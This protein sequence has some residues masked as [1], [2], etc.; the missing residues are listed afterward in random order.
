MTF[1]DFAR[2]AGR[3]L[4]QIPGIGAGLTQDA[5]LK[6]L[7]TDLTPFVDEIDLAWQAYCEV[8]GF[9]RAVGEYRRDGVVSQAFA[10]DLVDWLSPDVTPEDPPESVLRLLSALGQRMAAPLNVRATAEAIGMTRDRLNL[11]LNR[12]LAT[13]GAIACRQVDAQGEPISGSQ[14][15]MY[16]MD[17]L[18]AS[19]P[20][21]V[22]PGLAVP[23]MS[24]SSEAVLAST[25]A[26]AIDAVH[27]G[28]LLE[29]RAI[30]YARTSTKLEVDFAPMPIRVGGTALATAPMESKWVSDGWRPGARTMENHY[31]RGFV[32]TKNV[33]DLEHPAWA[34]PAGVLA[35]LLA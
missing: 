10:T 24:V 17:P 27:Q 9:P 33:L 3:Q 2:T 22:E 12:L 15:K 8:G 18:L 1:R 32:A 11:R 4:P 35:L 28:R 23:Q 19:L 29:G 21:L 6:D 14:S 34:V 26:R 31:G 7:L 30:G 5:R 13:F 25:L 20:N 16:L